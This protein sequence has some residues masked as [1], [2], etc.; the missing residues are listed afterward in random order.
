MQRAN[1]SFELQC[2]DTVLHEVGAMLSEDTLELLA[3]T[4]KHISLV[5]HGHGCH[6]DPGW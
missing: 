2:A 5:L 1:L 4:N 3:V 6:D